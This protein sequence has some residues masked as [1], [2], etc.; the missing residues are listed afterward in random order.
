MASK[1]KSDF[2]DEQI[3]KHL[4]IHNEENSNLKLERFLKWCKEFDIEI[5]FNK[6]ILMNVD[7]DFDLDSNLHIFE[8]LKSPVIKHPT[9]LAW[10]Q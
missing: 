4:K 3:V 6:V 9:I 1:N 7:F 5:D 10:L 2:E 8:R